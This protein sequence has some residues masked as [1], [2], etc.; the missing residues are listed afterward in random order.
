MN[1]KQQL[2]RVA[3]G[4]GSTAFSLEILVLIAL[5][6]FAGPVLAILWAVLIL[7][8]CITHYFAVEKLAD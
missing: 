2:E 5:A 8:G 6:K 7:L 4:A 1:E 3:N